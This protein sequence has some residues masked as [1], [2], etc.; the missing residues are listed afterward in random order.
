MTTCDFLIFGASGMQGSIVVRDLVEH[1]FSIWVSCVSQDELEKIL[2]RYPG[3]RG[4]TVDLRNEAATEKIIR[5]AGPRVII[6][7]AEGDWNL[8][9]YRAAL[10]TGV[11]VIDLGSDI[12]MTR[13]QMDLH[14][15]FAE[16]DLCAITGCGSTPGINNI[17]LARAIQELDEVSVVEAGFAWDSNIKSF[18][19]PFSMQSI[20]EEFT[21][22]ATILENGVWLEK[23]PLE[24]I[25]RR[26]FREI[27]TQRCML[28]PHP[29][30]YTFYRSWQN[31]G[32]HT[33]RFY[34]GFP[35]HSFDVIQSLIEKRDG[36]GG[37]AIAGEGVVPL[38]ALTKVCQR[39]YPR[40]A[41]YTERENLWLTIDGRA[42]G[43]PRRITMECI[44]PT[45]PDWQEAGCNIDTGLPASSIAQMILD[46]TITARGSFE[47]GTAVPPAPFFKRLSERGMALYMDGERMSVE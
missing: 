32:L 29:E 31:R 24:T 13:Q 20:I 23:Q 45:L 25:E 16:R 15:D 7:C 41:G 5:D 36:T 27:G 10:A 39:L 9:V 38:S 43:Q 37:V 14:A 40:P 4:A 3:V 33:V 8:G 26:T 18:V 12:P 1:G 17:A 19:V 22:P 42:A 6:N 35:D 28:A 11:H 30:V 2:A 21:Q 44:V 46:G 34:A 47:A